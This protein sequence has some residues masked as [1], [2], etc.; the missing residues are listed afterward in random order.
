MEPFAKYERLNNKD[1]KEAFYE[2]TDC[3]YYYGVADPYGV[4]NF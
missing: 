1:L 2:K 3:R 4:M